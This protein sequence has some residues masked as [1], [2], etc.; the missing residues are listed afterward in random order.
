MLTNQDDTINYKGVGTD[1]A[2][3]NSYQSRE[4]NMELKMLILSS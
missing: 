4:V 2:C 1:I 3:L